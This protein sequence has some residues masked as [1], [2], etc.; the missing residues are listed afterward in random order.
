MAGKRKVHTPAFN[1]RVALAVLTRDRTVN[2]L[3]EQF[4][5]HTN[6][7]PR[8]EEATA[9]RG[10]G[11][12]TLAT[13]FCPVDLTEGSGRYRGDAPARSVALRIVSPA[14]G[15]AVTGRGA[16]ERTVADTGA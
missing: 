2:E 14:V 13:R 16:H 1:A 12:P 11:G 15:G 7:D 5:V 8:Q 9:G 4:D 6:A 3:A 10:R